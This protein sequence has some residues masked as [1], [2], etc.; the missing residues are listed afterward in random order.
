MLLRFLPPAQAALHAGQLRPFFSSFFHV[1][2]VVVVFLS[3]GGG[4]ESLS[5]S[6]DRTQS[7]CFHCPTKILSSPVLSWC[8]PSSIFSISISPPT[9]PPLNPYAQGPASVVHHTGDCFDSVLGGG[10]PVEDACHEK[11]LCLPAVL[12]S[13]RQGIHDLWLLVP[14]SFLCRI[15]TTA[16]AIFST[17]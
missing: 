1:V 12:H 9:S 6:Q 15:S 3:F 14:I 17:W 7:F 13:T 5:K 11:G 10:N 2:R 4:R 8:T 16:G